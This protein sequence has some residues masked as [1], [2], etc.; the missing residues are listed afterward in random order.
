MSDVFIPSHLE[1]Y[2]RT[3]TFPTTFCPG[4]GCGT[5]LHCYIS[6]LSELAIE[7]QHTVSVSGIGCSS[8]IPSP[9]FKGDTLHSTHGRSV[10]FA[11][12]IKIMKP[13]KYVTVIAGDGDLAGIGLSHLIHAARRNI[14]ISVFLVN[15]YVFGMT[16]G[17]FS[18]TTPA[19][20][21]T[22]TSP[23]KNLESS[24]P[25][26]DIM[27]ISGAN[28]VARW[29]TYHVKDL[30]ESMKTSFQTKGFSFIEIISPCP[31]N[32]GKFIGKRN[33]SDFLQFFKDHSIAVEKAHSLSSEQK[34]DKFIVGQLAKKKTK[35]LSAALWE[36]TRDQMEDDG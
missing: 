34:E 1:K 21:K 28:Y 14:G 30:I 24:L 17:Q 11:T 6:A 31:M 10:A 23:F 3:E 27:A 19:G 20:V 36:L 22:T 13:G 2:I 33:P 4:C 32:Y 12:G 18:S 29:T 8:W 15:N 25:I 5:I 9:H 26:A 16:G 7:P 35:E